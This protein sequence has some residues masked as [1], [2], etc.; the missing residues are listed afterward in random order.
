M[1]HR[2][3]K[4]PAITAEQMEHINQLAIQSGLQMMQ[5]ME[6]AGLHL[7]RFVVD[8]HPNAN[9]ILVLAGPGHNG[10]DGLAS[11]RMLANWGYTVSVIVTH[12]EEQLKEMTMHQLALLQQMKLP[13]YWPE[14]EA[15]VTVF[16]QADVLIDA[17]L[18]YSLINDPLE[19]VASLIRLINQ[20]GKPIIACDTPSGLDVTTGKPYADC[21]KA[22]ETLTLAL[23][24]QGL[25]NTGSAE[26]TGDI[27]LADMGI[28]QFVLHRAMIEM[29]EQLFRESSRIEL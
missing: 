17:L 10:G 28:P 29:P 8:K 23:P 20:S 16:K 5:M 9:H 1:N 19:P 27:Y 24:K 18:G 3:K 13:V 11:A 2:L 6:H 7:A 22:T 12:N 14:E 21:V 4:I 26:Y 25:M 15:S